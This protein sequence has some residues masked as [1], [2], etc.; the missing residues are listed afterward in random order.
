MMSHS[1]SSTVNLLAGG[2][3]ESRI[4]LHSFP[5]LADHRVQDLPVLPGSLFIELA[6]SVHRDVLQRTEGAIRNVVFHQPVI[7]SPEDTVL[8]VDVTEGPSGAVHYAFYEAGGQDHDS[9]PVTT[10]YAATLEVDTTPRLPDPGAFSIA[11]F[12]AEAQITTEGEQFYQQLGDRGNDYGPRFRKIS[13]IWRRGDQVLGRISAPVAGADNDPLYSRLSLLDAATQLVAS[14]NMETNTT[15]MLKS[16]ERIDTTGIDVPETLW[17]HATLQRAAAAEE[18]GVIGRV[19]IFD[20]AGKYHAELSGI[21]LNRLDRAPAAPEDGPRLVIAGNFTLEPLEDSLRFWSDHFDFRMRVEFAPYNQVFQQLLDGRSALRRNDNGANAILLSLEEWTRGPYSAFAAKEHTEAC[22][23]ARQRFLLPNGLE[24]AHLNAYETEYVYKEVFQDLCYLKHGIQIDDGDTVVDIGANIGLFSL[25]VMSR[26][27]DTT[28]LAFEPAPVL[29]DLLKANCDAYG[30]D[31]RAFNLGV[32]HAP[33]TATFT[34][35]ERASVFSSFYPDDDADRQAIQAVVRNTLVTGASIE[36]DLVAPYV[37]ELTANRLERQTCECRLTTVSDII[38]ENRLERI[39]LLK[40]DAER[41]ELDILAG[42]ADQDWSRIAQMV[43]EVHDS[44]GE[45]VKR[46]RSLLQEKGYRCAVEHEA[47]LEHSGLVNLYARRP[48]LRRE[49]RPSSR[50]LRLAG[51]LQQNLL[52]FRAALGSFSSRTNVPLV[53]CISPRSPAAEGDAEL[54]TALDGIETM[55]LAEARAMSSVS[56]IGSAESLGRYQV[57]DYYDP[58]SVRIGHVP[59][60]PACFAAMG[61]LLSRTVAALSRTQ[62]K[63]IVL[64]CDNTLWRGACGEDGW[65]NIEI[66]EPYLRL[67]Q[68]MVDQMNAGRLLCLCSKN[69]EQDVLDV[70]EWRTDMVLQQEHVVARRINWK[71]KSENIKSL[72]AELN[73]ALDS[74]I[75]VDDNPVDCAEVSINCPDVL[76][77]RLPDNAASLPSFLNHVW[78]FDHLVGTDEDRRR[79]RMYQ[80]DTERHEFREQAQSLK[81]YVTGLGLRIDIAEVADDQLTRVSQLTFRT[82]QFNFT[83]IRRSEADIRR[84]LGRA[85]AACLTVRV[86]DRFGDYGLVGVLMYESGPDRLT[87]DT[88]LLSCRVLGRG[89]EHAVLSELGQ[90]A[91]RDGKRWVHLSYRPTGKNVPAGEFLAWI[92]APFREGEE[93]HCCIPA[94]YLARLTY[95]PDATPTTGPQAP[96]TIAKNQVQPK[97][98][99]RYHAASRTAQLASVAERFGTIQQLCLAIDDRRLA[100]AAVRVADVVPPASGLET[101][102]AAIWSRVLGRSAI[103]IH[104]N[105]FDLGGTSLRAVQAIALIKKELKYDLSIVSVFECPTISLL[106]VRLGGGSPEVAVAAT[107]AA[108]ARGHKRRQYFSRRSASKDV[109]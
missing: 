24:V 57:P 35:Y 82:N 107:A 56:A 12:Q 79:T 80:E 85:H 18:S 33:G 103:G 71:N 61:T 41:S 44:T 46:M 39:D 19:H 77:L 58:H 20:E 7:L 91:A 15:F 36:A 5:Y 22:F 54:N 10:R 38:R 37:K 70:F 51:R 3:T 93:T 60:T 6:R 65:R 2:S 21:V 89:V 47:L 32:S 17:G 83:A 59:Y 23:G 101:A 96:A 84:F 69:N 67:Q 109:I 14:F 29:Y 64:D 53:L 11:E 90:R 45:A 74:F 97:R 50:S 86:A 30:S 102:L 31:V 104:D 48:E 106:A 95:D 1:G 40:I 52:D 28:I 87:V 63:V 105:F 98:D 92:G 27:A 100:K 43:I 72:A 8:K 4:G 26:Y 49:V 55:L 81:D 62:F 73:V 9:S 108:F 68:F 16:V 75:F 25:F 66:T 13:S 42:I 99:V 94:E 88:F 78:A 76:T 34:Y